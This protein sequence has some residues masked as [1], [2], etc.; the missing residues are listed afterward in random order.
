MS[1]TCFVTVTYRMDGLNDAQKLMDVLDSLIEH[2][3]RNRHEMYFGSGMRY[4]AA[5]DLKR[6]GSTLH[7]S[8]AVVNSVEDAV[9]MDIVAFAKHLSSNGV[10]ECEIAYE[11]TGDQEKG[12]YTWTRGIKDRAGVP[13][14]RW[15]VLTHRYLLDADWPEGDWDDDDNYHA[16]V[17]GREFDDESECLEYALDAHGLE[18]EV[19]GC[20]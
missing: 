18:D 9:A 6:D 10:R 2:A 8:G 15:G 16:V 3:R 5:P 13:D 1:N 4:M 19:N 20:L 11:E 17:D 7:L 14:N 12:R